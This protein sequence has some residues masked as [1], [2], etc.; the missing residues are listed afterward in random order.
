MPHD[1]N[2]LNWVDATPLSIKEELESRFEEMTRLEQEQIQVGTTTPQLYGSLS[3]F[4]ANPS[5]VSV[6]TY[7]RMLD[8]DETL[9]SCMD[10]MLLAM[11]A[12]FGDYKHK[13]PEIQDFVRKAR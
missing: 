11:I 7:K 10:F 4:V 1:P 6:E 9:G 3:R 5:T 12:R 13:V 2:I 8:T